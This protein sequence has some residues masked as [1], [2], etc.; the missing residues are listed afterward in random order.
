M[1]VIAANQDTGFKRLAAAMGV[2]GLG[3]DTRFATHGDR[4]PYPEE[5][6]SI[7]EQWASRMTATELGKAL[8]AHAVPHSKIYT[9]RDMLAIPHFAAREAIVQVAHPEYGDVAMQNVVPKLSVTP[10]SVRS[11]GPAL[12]AHNHDVFV[13]LFGLS[14]SALEKLEESG[15]V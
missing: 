6:D 9:A 7:I 2:P 13:G 11:V 5:L 4:G 3:D 14:R 12:G 8:L 1:L 10:D 15:V